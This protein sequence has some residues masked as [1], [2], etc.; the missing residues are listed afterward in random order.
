[1]TNLN[2]RTPLA[3]LFLLVF[4]LE[5]AHAVQEPP[6]KTENF[7]LCTNRSVKNPYNYGNAAYTCD[8]NHFVDAKYVETEFA[9]LIFDKNADLLTE[10]RRYLS[11]THA[12]IRETA[13]YYMLKR[14]P[15]VSQEEMTWWLNSAYA[16]GNQES[17]WTHYRYGEN[18]KMQYMRGDY[19]H[20]HGI[21]QVDDRYHFLA[22][23]D[24]RAANI[25]MNM[26]YSLEEYY[27]AWEYAP[28]TSCVSSE[29][30]YRG[31]S[32]SAYSAYNGG[33]RRICRWTNPDDRWAR[34]DVGYITKFDAKKWKQYI[35]D[36]DIPSPVDIACIVESG[37]DCKAIKETTD[38]TP[39]LNKIYKSADFK[40]CLFDGEGFNCVGLKKDTTCLANSL[41]ADID[42]N[43]RI[44]EKMN[45]AFEV[46]FKKQ[47]SDRQNICDAGN[48]G[49]VSVGTHLKLQKNIN[50][51]TSPGGSKLATLPKGAVV[52][53]LDYEYRKYKIQE[54]FYRIRYNGDEGYI[55]GGDKND[56]RSW[57][58]PTIV[59]TVDSFIAK[60]ND[61]VKIISIKPL[62]VKNSN[63][64]TIGSVNLGNIL[65]VNNIHIQG[66]NNS[67]QYEF[68]FNGTTAFL[69]VGETSPN[70]TLFKTVKTLSTFTDTIDYNLATLQDYMYWVNA[71]S[72]A[73]MKC[74]EVG[75]IKGPK[76]TDEFLNIIDQHDDYYKVKQGDIV[77]WIKKKYV[78]IL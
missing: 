29:R 52:Q 72:C 2:I 65:K 67:I 50:L 71:R 21:F 44:I 76:L 20:G 64:D 34:N 31:R 55:Y 7:W 25:V 41:N 78:Q 48:K 56:N 23:T 27:E 16:I 32:R 1:M 63:G 5:L 59:N 9:P 39:K 40:Y 42:S 53:V 6:R 37:E 8:V 10:R 14:K 30:D 58:L 26:I 54:R 70:Y 68:D 36:F 66:D 38:T 51:R 22:V 35:T 77:G 74:F 28:K 57:L 19:G 17:Y 18:N 4:G 62:N 43:S 49:F 33:L 73:S 12:L 46:D 3:L 15:N 75:Q 61:R 13:R 47:I 24:G 69:H 60:R 45:S 11:L